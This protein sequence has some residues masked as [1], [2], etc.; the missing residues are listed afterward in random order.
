MRWN[1][2]SVYIG[3]W[4]RGIQHGKGKMTFPD[5]SLIEGIFQNNIYKGP[6]GP[7]RK[8]EGKNQ[9]KDTNDFARQII[10]RAEIVGAPRQ[11]KFYLEGDPFDPSKQK[12][13]DGLQMALS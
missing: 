3:E 8:K 13:S 2:G 4:L 9:M 10:E 6:D 7:L 5:G 1:D 12:D 11:N